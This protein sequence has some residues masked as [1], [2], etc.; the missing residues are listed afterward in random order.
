MNYAGFKCHPKMKVEVNKFDDDRRHHNA[1]HT[2]H[3]EA[4]QTTS[5]CTQCNEAYQTSVVR[6]QRNEAYQT[7]TRCGPD[8]RLSATN[9]TARLVSTDENKIVIYEEIN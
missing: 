3:N 4:Y 1:V 9:P 2:Q 8:Q 6:T 5:V 7:A